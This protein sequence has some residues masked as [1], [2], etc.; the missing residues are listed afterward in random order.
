MTL[1]LITKKGKEPLMTKH[2]KYLSLLFA[3]I[4]AGASLT[5]AQEK[6]AKLGTTK[7]HYVSQGKGKDAIVLVHGWGGD[8]TLWRDQIA[9]FSKRT[10]VIAVD[11]RV[12]E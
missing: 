3:V 2:L 9:E 7:I 8:L 5:A 6:Y 1:V 12:M 4:L 10:R 11:C